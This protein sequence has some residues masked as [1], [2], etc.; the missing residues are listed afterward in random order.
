[1]V[2]KKKK[3][4]LGWRDCRVTK[5]QLWLNSLKPLDCLL[6]VPCYYHSTGL[7]IGNVLA[8]QLR[9]NNTYNTPA[10]TCI[11]VWRY[12]ICLTLLGHTLVKHLC[13]LFI[14]VVRM[15]L[16]VLIV[17]P[18]YPPRDLDVTLWRSGEE[19]RCWV[20]FSAKNGIF[21][22]LTGPKLR[23]ELLKLVL[24][25]NRRTGEYPFSPV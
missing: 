10:I 2:K 22:Y 17:Y 12:N 7:I 21:I 19:K 13:S 1:M 4:L 20:E 14:L 11:H 16:S 15:P 5:G 23:G 6:F 25:I 8:L 3:K 18:E 24:R 9:T